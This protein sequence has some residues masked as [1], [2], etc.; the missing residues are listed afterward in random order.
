MTLCDESDCR[1]KL[2]IFH[3]QV[4]GAVLSTGATWLAYTYQS[5]GN[6]APDVACR[7]M[8]FL[9][10]C[11]ASPERTQSICRSSREQL[12]NYWNDRFAHKP[13][14]LDGVWCTG[15]ESRLSE[16]AHSEWGVIGTPSSRTNRNRNYQCDTGLFTLNCCSTPWPPPPSPK[17]PPIARE[18]CRQRDIDRGVGGCG[19]YRE[20]AISP[21]VGRTGGAVALASMAVFCLCWCYLCISIRRKAKL[22]SG[23]SAHDAAKQGANTGG[24]EMSNFKAVTRAERYPV[25]SPSH[26]P[27]TFDPMTGVATFLP[28]GH[29]PVGYLTSSP[30][31]MRGGTRPSRPDE[32]AAFLRSPDLLA[33]LDGH[34]P[35]CVIEAQLATS[36]GWTPAQAWALGRRQGSGMLSRSVVG[37]CRSVKASVTFVLAAASCGGMWYMMLVHGICNGLQGCPIGGPFADSETKA[38][39]ASCLL[40]SQGIVENIPGMAMRMLVCMVVLPL[41]LLASYHAPEARLFVFKKKLPSALK[42]RITITKSAGGGRMSLRRRHEL[43]FG[44]TAS[45]DS[46]D[47]S[48]A[49]S[50]VQWLCSLLTDDSP[51]FQANVDAIRMAAPRI[52]FHV[53]CYNEVNVEHRQLRSRQSRSQMNYGIS[54][55]ISDDDYETI[56]VREKRC[57]FANAAAYPYSA[58]RDVSGNSYLDWTGLVG[59]NFEKAVAFANEETRLHFE[60]FRAEHTSAVASMV[61]DCTSETAAQEAARLSANPFH[62]KVRGLPL[63]D[64]LRSIVELG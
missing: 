38:R 36:S 31:V 51:F 28:G 2:M 42:G 17:P 59:A 56:I 14:W 12:E 16:C 48:E 7:Q 46:N 19:V 57:V 53:R 45:D 4:W 11:F 43:M 35:A 52:V 37:V 5:N 26:G 55:G 33:Q 22:S 20:R 63:S 50:L 40:G 9:R 34:A 39:C 21:P 32:G 47:S 24:V 61:R 60:W 44:T 64:G 3:D 30:P 29:L 41:Y 1:P 13:L 23:L 15:A 6:R 58:V 62:E 10:A 27:S 25:Q 49:Q 54:G 18:D 8:G